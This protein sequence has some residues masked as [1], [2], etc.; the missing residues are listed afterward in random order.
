MSVDK[1]SHMLRAMATECLLKALWLKH[2]GKLAE[3]GRYVGVM[4]KNEHRLHDLVEA[5]S[6]KGQIN[7]TKR[8]LDLL[9]QASYWILTGRYPIQKDYF[10]LALS[11]RPDGTVAPKQYWRG[12]AP[13]LKELGVL[14]AKLQTALGFEMR[15]ESD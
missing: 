5:V 15:F 1:V 14:I 13:P 12:D 9:E 10:S 3:N 7:F 4:K 11:K 6:Q 8:E 2:G